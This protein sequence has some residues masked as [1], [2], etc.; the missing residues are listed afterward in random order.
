MAY[1]ALKRYSYFGQFGTLIGFIGVGIIVAAII[2]AIPILLNPELSNTLIGASKEEIMKKLLVPENATMLRILQFLSTLFMFFLPPVFYA[3]VCHKKTFT[4][5]GFSKPVNWQQ[6]YFVVL[7]MFACLPLVSLL[8]QFTEALPFSEATMNKFK[9][10]E[11]EYE[12]QIEAIGRMNNFSDYLLSLFMIAI[13]PS[14]F[15]ETFFRGGLQNLFSRWFK[16]PIVAIVITS[17]IFSA[18]HFSYI[19]FLS[20]VVL[21]M[22]L[23]WMYYRTGNLWLSIIGHVV[24][25]G[26]GMTVLYLMKLNNPGFKMSD[27]GGDFPVWVGIISTA[28]LV[29]LLFRFEKINKHQKDKPGEEELMVVENS[30][31]PSW[32]NEQPNNQTQ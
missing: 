13:L 30:S 26:V 16:A 1:P 2:Q 14:I 6:L 24:N 19:G 28:F 10:A 18:V 12:Q 11:K 15:E 20:R 29:L 8:G 23:G 21:G 27:A 7:I 25:N 31:N 32:L 4:H 17:L 3:M 5:L 22:V 9:L